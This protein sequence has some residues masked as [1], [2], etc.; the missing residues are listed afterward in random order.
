M[1]RHRRAVILA[2]GLL[3]LLALPFA[4]RAGGALRAGG[5][6]LD[7]LE[8]A[9]AKA[10]LQSPNCTCRRRPS[11]SSSTPTRS[12]PDSPPFEAAA[13]SAMAKV[14]SS[15]HVVSVLSHRTAPRQVQRR[16]P[17]RVR[18]RVPSTWR[19]TTRRSPCPR[20]QA[21]LGPAPG[22]DVALAGGPAFYGDVQS[23]SESDLRRSEIISLP[24]A[25]A[26][27]AARLRQP[28]RG[29]RAARGRRL[30]GDRGAGGHLR[31]GQPHADEH[32]RPEPRDAARARAR[33]RLLAADHE[34]LPRG[35]RARAAGATDQPD[36]AVAGRR[37]RDRRDGGPGGL[38]L[39]A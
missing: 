2:W 29:G 28:R 15:A 18:H 10:L 3:L 21:A 22:L 5:F 33:R 27:P 32:L 31:R 13:A 20:S 17:H 9:K 14:P 24:L 26:R 23:V 39:A 11:S 19:P 30:G 1:Y 37:R 25:G 12:Q 16:R 34:P 38:L 7:T 36:G 6:T 8:S 4:P 35:A